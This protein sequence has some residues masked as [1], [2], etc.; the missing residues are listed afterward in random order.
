MVVLCHTGPVHELG[1]LRSVTEAVQAA[2]VSK[3]AVAVS[4]VGL[5][6]GTLSGAVPEALQGAWPIATVDTL[7]A[8]AR[9]EVETVQ[10][11]IWCHGCAVEQPV[12]EFYALTCPV[13]GTPSGNLVRGREFAVAFADLEYADHDPSAC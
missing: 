5:R 3:D 7:V 1:L 6:V 10:A 12:D 8:G 2:A 9:L 13:C 4:V 11:A